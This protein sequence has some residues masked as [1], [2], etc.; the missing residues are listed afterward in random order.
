MEKSY[1]STKI[2]FCISLNICIIIYFL[3]RIF[4]QIFT[5]LWNNEWA[6][7][8]FQ[9]TQTKSVLTEKMNNF[10]NSFSIENFIRFLFTLKYI[11]IYFL[12]LNFGF[13]LLFIN[14]SPY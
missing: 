1:I 7:I 13:T 3:L 10:K 4:L 5:L 14:K 8:S 12:S 11:E 2:F 9:C 6:P